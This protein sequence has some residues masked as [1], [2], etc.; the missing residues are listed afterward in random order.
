MNPELRECFRQAVFR[1]K[2]LPADWPEAFAIITAYNQE[3]RSDPPADNVAADAS[4]EAKLRAEGLRIHRV[5][6]GSADGSHLEPGW[7]A[8]L[9]LSDAIDIGRHYRQAAV[10]Y[11]RDGRLWLVDCLDGTVEA[12]GRGFDLI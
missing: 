3:G 5:T 12:L 1:G 11:V 10:F 7:A 8:S 9:S 4:L 6:G 2:P